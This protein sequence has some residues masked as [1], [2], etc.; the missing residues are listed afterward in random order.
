[1]KQNTITFRQANYLS[2]IF[3]IP[4]FIIKLDKNVRLPVFELK[5]KLEKIQEE[6]KFK[7]TT[8]LLLE[9][10]IEIENKERGNYYDMPPLK[11]R[12]QFTGSDE[13]FKKEIEKTLETRN[14]IE[15]KILH[16]AEQPCS[17]KIN[18]IF[19]EEQFENLFQLIQDL[20]WDS[21]RDILVIPSK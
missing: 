8:I 20:E 16:I 5:K 18:P 7:R 4:N 19:N 3:S 14:T 13:E 2:Q 9:G 12:E 15:Q 10:G 21:L 1:M 11:T 6:F 17:L